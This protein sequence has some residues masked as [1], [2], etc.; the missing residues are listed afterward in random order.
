[1]L[2]PTGI[3]AI[4]RYSHGHAT[5]LSTCAGH[6]ILFIRLRHLV[7]L[8]DEWILDLSDQT[9]FQPKTEIRLQNA[10]ISPNAQQRRF[11]AGKGAREPSAECRD[12]RGP[13]LED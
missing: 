10:K 8:D 7:S 2:T 12:R 5:V 4:R 11:A 9:N 6:A 1:M 3:G 13:C